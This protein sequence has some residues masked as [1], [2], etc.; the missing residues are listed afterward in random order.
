MSLLEA[1]IIYLSAGAP[2][3]VLV[4]FS[5]RSAPAPLAILN[6]FLATA[7]WPIVG[8]HRLYRGLV[9][10]RDRQQRVDPAEAP[11]DVLRRLSQQVPSEQAEL[12][13]IAGHPNPWLATNCYAR[14]RKRVIDSH[15]ERSSEISPGDRTP[16]EPALNE[17]VISPKYSTVGTNLT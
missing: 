4:F 7:G 11:I 10:S 5:R 17:A 14:S 16:N 8:T 3:G 9:R 15:I 1:I 12:F 2:F 6:A 13:E